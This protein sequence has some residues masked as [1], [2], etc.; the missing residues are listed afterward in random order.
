MRDVHGLS[1][2]M[3]G[4]TLDDL[5][6]T[7]ERPWRPWHPFGLFN[8]H[9]DVRPATLIDAF[10][11]AYVDEDEGV[12]VFHPTIEAFGQDRIGEWNISLTYNVCMI[13]LVL[14]GVLVPCGLI[15]S[16]LSRPSSDP[17]AHRVT[18]ANGTKWKTP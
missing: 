10:A 18:R 8:G 1:W 13:A 17:G 12:Y 6:T 2:D 7:D 11:Q 4:Q 16:Y 9:K 14:Y 3:W 5:A 15:C